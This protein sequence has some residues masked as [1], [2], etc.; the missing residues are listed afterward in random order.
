M[1]TKTEAKLNHLSNAVDVHRSNLT[2]AASS[3]PFLLTDEMCDVDLSKFM[4][5]VNFLIISSI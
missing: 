2:S 5:V 4:I 3:F 1:Q